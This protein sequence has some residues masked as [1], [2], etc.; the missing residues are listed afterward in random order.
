[1]P[2]NAIGLYTNIQYM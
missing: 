1:M 2:S